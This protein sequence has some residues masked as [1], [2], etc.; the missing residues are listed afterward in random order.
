M[1][2]ETKA[3]LKAQEEEITEFFIYSLLASKLGNEKNKKVLLD[4]AKE[5]KGHYEK[6]K[7]ISK[8]E[9]SPNK[10]KIYFYYLVSIIFGIIFSM[11]LMERGE[12]KAQSVYKELSKKHKVI[13]DILKDEVRHEQALLDLLKEEKVEYA[14][15]VVLGL[16]D[17]LVE[18]TGA[19]VGLTFALQNAQLVGLSGLIVG[20]AASLSMAVS[21]YLSSKEDKDVITDK[22]PLKSAFYTGI[23]YIITVLILVS[24]YFLIQENIY[25]SLGFTLLLGIGVVG[26]YTFYITVAKDQKFL[27]RFSEMI[28]LSGIVAVISLLSGTFLRWYFGIEEV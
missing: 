13:K 27:P 6:L 19:L 21:S 22:E 17:A 3:I 28:L 1:N 10:I 9:V 16:N 4:L 26:F 18:L 7:K 15:A 20:I 5:E 25:L 12:Q 8:T 24:P 14:G 2:K 11:R 23:A